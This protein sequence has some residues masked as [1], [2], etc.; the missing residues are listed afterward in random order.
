MFQRCEVRLATAD[1]IPGMLD[2]QERNLPHRGGTLS[3]RFSHAWFEAAIAAMPVIAARRV[4][5]VVGYLVSSPLEAHANV[6]V[7]Q[8]MLQAYRGGSGAY[9]YGPICVEERGRGV[10]GAMFGSLKARLP[11][12]EGILFIRRDNE[13]SLRAHTKMGMQ[14]VADFEHDDVRFVVLSYFG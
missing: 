7:V 13:A 14:D 9:V 2:L 1:D 8:A 4:E 3:A 11:R 6:P 12:R 5:K 10:A